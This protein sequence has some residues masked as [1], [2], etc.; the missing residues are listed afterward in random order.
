MDIPIW[1]IYDTDVKDNDEDKPNA[2]ISHQKLNEYIEGLKEDGTI[3]DC[4][5]NHPNLE[6]SL[7][8]DNERSNK[9]ISIYHKLERNDRNCRDSDKYKEINLFVKE[10]LKY[11]G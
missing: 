7:G 9:D 8:L 4:L 6:E 5:G 2:Y 11:K 1:I 3:R 10:T